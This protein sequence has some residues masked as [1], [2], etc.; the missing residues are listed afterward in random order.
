MAEGERPI[1]PEKQLLKL[2]ENPKGEVPSAQN[3]RRKGGLFSLDALRARFT[4]LKSFSFLQLSKKNF[5]IKQ[6]NLILKGLILFLTIYLG[7]TVVAMAIQLKK[8]SNLIFEVKEGPGAAAPEPPP[9]FIQNLEYYQEKIAVR[10]IFRPVRPKEE[11]KPAPEAAAEAPVNLA[12]DFIL[13]GI[14]WSDDPEAMIEDT[15]EKRTY[16]VKRGQTFGDSVTVAKILKD[17]VILTIGDKEVEL[18]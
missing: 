15:T 17:R 11:A 7:Y 13:V 2:I 12:K 4:F 16:F 5:G 9:F 18:K 1:T 10:D 3:A 14:A 6:V 8:A